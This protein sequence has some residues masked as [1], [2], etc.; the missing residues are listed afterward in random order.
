MC[1]AGSPEIKRLE[2]VVVHSPSS[3]EASS[4]AEKPLKANVNELAE[5]LDLS[6]PR[7]RRFKFDSFVVGKSN[8]LAHVALSRV[9]ECSVPFNPLYIYGGVGLGKTHLMHA[10]AH[11]LREK[12]PEKTVMISACK[13]VYV[14]ICAG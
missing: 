11:E 8:A 9:V 7:Y 1:I 14:S 6:S 2:I 4:T 12:R 10:I 3:A 13:K 5:K